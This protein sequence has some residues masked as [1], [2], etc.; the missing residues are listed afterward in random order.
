MMLAVGI[1]I[2]PS[3]FPG[4]SDY[5]VQTGRMNTVQHLLQGRPRTSEST[6]DTIYRTFCL[7]LSPPQL[8]T[9]CAIYIDVVLSSFCKLNCKAHALQN[10]KD[11]LPRLHWLVLANLDMQLLCA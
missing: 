6:G 3:Q 5:S 9:V 4:H 2:N 7:S 11:S 10:S 8:P 1:K